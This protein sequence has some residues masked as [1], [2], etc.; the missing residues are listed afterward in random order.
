MVRITANVN[1][2]TT[3]LADVTGFSF[4]LAANRFYA[5]DFFVIFQSDT[6]TTGIRFAVNGPSNNFFVMQKIIPTSLVA[7]QAG[8]M[9]R[10]VNTAATPSASV[11]VANANLLARLWGLINPTANGNLVLRFAAETTGTV[12]VMA[13]SVGFLYTV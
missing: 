13:N 2:S 4:S 8:Q 1:N 9:E 3:M 7:N 12:R 5:F 6:A 11:D 10:A